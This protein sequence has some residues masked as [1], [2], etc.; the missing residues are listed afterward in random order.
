[1]VNVILILVHFPSIIEFFGTYAI[2]MPTSLSPSLFAFTYDFQCNK[3]FLQPIIDK[4][5]QSR[6][7]IQ[8]I[9]TPYVF[10]SQKIIFINRT[11]I[12]VT[13]EKK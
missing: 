7:I 13:P 12:Q 2:P 9:V 4:D 11:I 3:Y 6:F 5:K 1:M 10:I 8:K